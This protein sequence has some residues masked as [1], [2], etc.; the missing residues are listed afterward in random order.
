[1]HLNQGGGCS[2]VFFGRGGGRGHCPA[3]RGSLVALCANRR[4]IYFCPHP[5]NFVQ[6]YMRYIIIYHVNQSFTLSY[7]PALWHVMPTAPL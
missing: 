6:A 7:S 3:S 4:I 2:S 1:M 5:T